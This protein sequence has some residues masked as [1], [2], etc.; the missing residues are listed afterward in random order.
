MADITLTC[1]KC[2]EQV[3]ISESLS[4]KQ[5]LCP[6]CGESIAVPNLK[7]R[8]GGLRLRKAEPPQPSREKPDGGAREK[9]AATVITA[10]IRRDGADNDVITTPGK[11]GRATMIASWLVF[12]ILAGVLSYFRYVG[13]F[14]GIPR[15]AFIRY[16]VMGVA[17]CYVAIIIAAL[18][19][20]MFD[21][22]LCVIVPL[23]PFY[24]ILVVSNL[25]YFRAVAAAMLI[26][27]GYDVAM[28]LQDVWNKVFDGVSRWIQNS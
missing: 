16:G 4:E 11:T 26:A 23:Y 15:E 21:G 6:F 10:S 13:S 5:T 22:L 12:L 9:Q 8:S 20:N 19:D 17:V 28:L 25:V 3:D 18:R 14:A 1:S 27:F 24:Y 2:N 7:K